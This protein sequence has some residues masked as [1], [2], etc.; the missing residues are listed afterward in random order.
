MNIRIFFGRFSADKKSPANC[1]IGDGL[2]GLVRKVIGR[3]TVHVDW[4]TVLSLIVVQRKCYACRDEDDWTVTTEGD[5]ISSEQDN[6]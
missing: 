1:A 3:K 5:T 4:V 2:E 6:I